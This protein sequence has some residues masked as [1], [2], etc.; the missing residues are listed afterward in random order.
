MCVYISIIQIIYVCIYEY[1]IIHKHNPY[2]SIVSYIN[3]C[4][5][6]CLCEYCIIYKYNLCVYVSIVSYINII[7]V[8]ICEYSIDGTL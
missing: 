8:C 4:V 6:V 7:C 5:C 2:I 3:I 1:S